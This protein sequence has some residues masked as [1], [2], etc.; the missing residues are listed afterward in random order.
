MKRLVV[1]AGVFLLLASQKIY[2]ASPI[3]P[4]LTGE[5]GIIRLISA[6]SLPATGVM[7]GTDG[8]YFRTTDLLNTV[9]DVNERLEGNVNVTYGATNWLEIFLNEA[10]SAQTIK[11]SSTSRDDLYQMLGDT[12]L[13]FKMGY[14]ASP[15]LAIGFDAFAKLMTMPNQLGYQWNASNFGAHMLWTIDLDAVQNIPFRF[16]LNIGYKWDRSRYLLSA[17]NYTL[18]S[19]GT[20]ASM[21]TLGIPQSEEEY[22][23]GILH[24]DQVLGAIGVEFPSPYLTPFVQYYTDQIVNTGRNSSLPHLRYNE[25]PEFI[26]PGLR[27]TP[28]KGI[29][30]DLAS[31]IG[32]TKV[33]T[34]PVSGNPGVTTNVRS[35]PLWDIVLGASYTILPGAMV[36]IQKIQ[37][38]PPP[39]KGRIGGV[40]L[41]E[42]SRQPLP[43]VIIRFPGKDV[44]DIISGDNGS[45]VSC[46]M[47]AGPVKLEFAKEGYLPSTLEGS[48]LTGQ[49]SSQ[50]ILLKKLVQIGALAGTVTDM[51]GK[52]LAAVI[53][54]ANTTLPPAAS[55][56]RT[57][58]YF[59]KLSPGD[60]EITVSAQGYV[61]K[62]IGV[63]IKNMIKTIAN[64]VL[65]QKQAALPPPPPPPAPVVTEK[66]PRV[67]L[68]K[69]QKKIVI[70]EAIHF[71]TGRATIL[72]DS[73]SLLNEI[74][75]VL[76]DNPTISVRVEGYTDN[77]G[78]A[79]YNLRL[80]QARADSVM[81]YLVSQ[82]ISPDRVEA[83]G[84][85][86]MEPIASNKTAEGRAKNRRV[87][88]T[89]TKE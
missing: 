55:D 51:T 82:G 26:T 70:T 19:Y 34:L 5:T 45:F 38:P 68:E 85:G 16:H 54:F 2:A 29:A 81:R 63:Q 8:L 30:V 67:I 36:V 44:S 88:F 18:G 58:A 50:E 10:S 62:T 13:G 77:V 47:N 53:T 25:S 4:A 48:I 83:R 42:Q 69:A 24:D 23:L 35:V 21:Y 72:E 89:I 49:T 3:G 40:V 57:G 75:Q 22:A 11:N 27:F 79:R 9:G 14:L 86:M 17:P 73:Y 52:P 71:E 66:K 15:G 56:P 78:S 7:M 76:K 41:D 12:T 31:D 39:E 33:Q 64:F 61:S 65:E 60:Y 80:S 20:V 1:F 46:P 28:A 6:E 43:N 59:V 74:A 84:F 32:L 87:E 37:A